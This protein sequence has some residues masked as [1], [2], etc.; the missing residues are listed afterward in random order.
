[1]TRLAA[2]ICSL[3]PLWLLFQ[4]APAWAQPSATVPGAPESY[5]GHAVPPLPFEMD[6]P[7]PSLPPP[8]E[9]GAE[10]PLPPGGGHLIQRPGYDALIADDGR[11]LFDSRFL[12][13]GLGL[14]PLYGPSASATFDIGDSLI[15]IFRPG[16]AQDP[17]LSDKLD[18]LHET[19]SQRVHLREKHSELMMDRALAGLPGYLEA[20][21]EQE[22]WSLQTRRRILF[23]LWDECAENGEFAIREGGAEARKSIEAFLRKHATADGT[24]AYSAEELSALNQIRSSKAEFAPVQR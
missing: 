16:N 15:N 6:T 2:P 4:A 24:S 17:Y 13:N 1:M 19:F 10:E 11:L 7:M 18:L 14:D 8:Q 3:L 20:I 9:V 23:A 5:A 21:W 22:Q 12:R